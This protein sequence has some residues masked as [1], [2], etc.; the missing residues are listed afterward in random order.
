MTPKQAAVNAYAEFYEDLAE[1]EQRCVDEGEYAEA[2]RAHS[3]AMIALRAYDSEDRPLPP[4]VPAPRVSFGDPAYDTVQ[5]L[6]REL[7]H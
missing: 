4:L 7:G 5:R 1:L 6:R 2:E 3:A